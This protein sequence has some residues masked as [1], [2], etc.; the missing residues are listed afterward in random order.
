MT[1][2]KVVDRNELEKLAQECE[3]FKNKNIKGFSNSYLVSA[4][5][6][7]NPEL[8]KQNKEKLYKVK[9]EKED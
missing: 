6:D 7:S 9:E 4:I 3:K 8:L 2:K 1:T 5:K